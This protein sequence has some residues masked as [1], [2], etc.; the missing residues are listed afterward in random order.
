[1][2]INFHNEW[3]LGDCVFQLNYLRLISH[4]HPNKYTFNFYVNK[5]YISEL[6]YQ[7]TG[8][9]NITL[10]PL[11]KRSQNSVD[12]WIGANDYY[13]KY[14]EGRDK[15]LYDQFYV[16]YF[17]KLSHD[18]NLPQVCDSINCILYNHNPIFVDK[19][20]L[21]YDILLI[22]SDP[23]SSQI[24]YEPSDVDR[25]LDRHKKYSIITTQKVDGYDCTRDYGLNIAKIGVLSKN[26]KD[27]VAIHTSPV[28]PC[29]NHCTIAS[30]SRF[31]ILDRMNTYSFPKIETHISFDTIQI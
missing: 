10:Y 20:E 27:I 4:L 8:F 13:F 29:L 26:V 9:N 21:Y 28:I 12:C 17:N 25:F 3:H 18:L 5:N 2:H 15:V 16:E 1:M 22:N 7:I 30:V 31:I 6:E 24:E 23:L 11:N 14:K 19:S